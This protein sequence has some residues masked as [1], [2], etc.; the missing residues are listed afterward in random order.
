MGN[1]IIQEDPRD[2]EESEGEHDE[3]HNFVKQGIV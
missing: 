3:V 2:N 1:G